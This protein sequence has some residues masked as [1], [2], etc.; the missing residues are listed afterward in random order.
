MPPGIER[1]LNNPRYYGKVFLLFAAY[2][3]AARI[4]L[5]IN[6]VNKFASLV[7]APSGIAFAALLTQ[8]VKIW[9]GVFLAAFFANF[10]NGA[11]LIPALG[12]ATG[13]TLEPI[14]GAYL[15]AGPLKD[16][17][18]EKFEHVK[19]F[20][21]CSVLLSTA[22][23]ASV[24]VASLSTAN[25]IPPGQHGLTWFQW[26]VGDAIG[27][28]T[29]APLLL[30]CWE[31][32]WKNSQ[33]WKRPIEK[34]L[35]TLSLMAANFLVFTGAFGP[36]ITKHLKG[37]FVFPF[38]LWAVIRFG[39]PGAVFTSFLTSMFAIVAT[40]LGHGPFGGLPPND[41][42]LQLGIF[43]TVV[44]MIQLVIASVVVDREKSKVRLAQTNAELSSAL[45]TRDLFFSIASHELKTPLTS[46]RLQLE[47]LAKKLSNQTLQT[48]EPEE[49]DKSIRI[50]LRQVDS[51]TTLV[52]DLMD[53]ASIRSGHFSLNP[54]LTDL[55]EVTEEIV[56]R[57][58]AQVAAANIRIELK[59]ERKVTGPWDRRRME[60]VLINLIGNAVK[61]APGSVVRIEVTGTKAAARLVFHDSGPGIPRDVQ[62]RVF[63]RFERLK[64]D[65]HTPGLGLGLFIVKSIVL[66]HKGSVHLESN[67]GR[68]TSF[69]VILPR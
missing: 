55:A 68:G 61:Y 19:R 7:W 29:Y 27:I 36:G 34:I 4:G 10:L 56:A 23:S 42:A 49:L 30:V 22:V 62:S 40:S 12:I 17:S 48:Q 15:C 58:A 9:P 18:I 6:P 8:G 67:E 60:Q 52:D 54:G 39:M 37:P 5:S 26:W 43:I 16:F 35:L 59:L 51:L 1:Q 2:F 46:L 31:L 47:L 25:L 41:Q 44:T 28:L 3:L 21:L 33:L 53:V 14:V 32:E 38:L 50:S 65:L 66:A 57:L 63:E 64:A 45:A 24:G 13:N 11:P 20:L 69:V